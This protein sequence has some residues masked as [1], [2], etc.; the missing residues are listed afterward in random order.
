MFKII[1]LTGIFFIKINF[2]FS[3][4]TQEWEQRYYQ[5]TNTMDGSKSLVLDRAGNI[6]VTGSA[7]GPTNDDIVTIKYTASGQQLWLRSYNGVGNS[8][9]RGDKIKLDN[10]NNI[11]VLGNRTFTGNGSD[12]VLIKYSTFGTEE[13]LTTIPCTG[14]NSFPSTF[15][16]DKFNNIYVLGRCN[17]NYA[18]IK[19]FS[20]GKQHWVSQ[21]EA[22]DSFDRPWDLKL[23]NSRNIYIT[24]E[25]SSDCITIKYDSNGVMQWERIY[26][27]IGNQQDFTNSLELD[28]SGNIYV[29]G[30]SV[31]NPNHFGGYLTVKYNTEGVEEWVKIY[32]G[33][34]NF[35]DVAKAMKVD[36]SGNVYVTGYSTESGQ[37]YNMTT[38]KYNSHGDTIWKRTF[39]NGS[40]D[41]ATALTL[42]ESG[43]IYITGQ[44]DG[45]GGNGDDYATIKYDSSGNQKWVK[46]YNYQGPF[47]DYA[48]A[49]AVDNI[50]NV[51][52]TGQSNRDFLTIK[53]SQPTEIVFNQS[54]T[55]N[56]Y[57][58]I[59][60]Y[61][62]PFNPAT[63]FEYEITYMALVTIKVYDVLGSEVA[64]LVNEN[65][66][67]GR[68]EVKFD[69]SKISSGIYFY[70]LFV[71][72]NI[73]DTKSM[74]LVK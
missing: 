1:I 32:E 20:T 48:Q 73:I 53:Y 24:G 16:I 54:Y 30:S 62:N 34:A 11:I 13:W 29:S 59:Q 21:L 42:D 50:G 26:G 2:L 39:N 4:V 31:E 58:L 55:P 35:M 61:P 36:K 65:K 64:T 12:F 66:I 18:L 74:I 8:F 44:S 33:S 43:N 7:G 6:Y 72:G 56:E 25:K 51:Y 23:D 28:C 38:M 46:R 70:R 5:D 52:V 68:Y 14:S 45:V 22:P 37:G 3:Q 63:H 67:P 10:D 69:G 19:Y 15:E 57:K 47:G 41:I 27:G 71:D 9:D 40:N 60:N 49:I 17:N